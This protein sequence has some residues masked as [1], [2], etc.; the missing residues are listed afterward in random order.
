LASLLLDRGASVDHQ[1]SNGL[2][3]LMWFCQ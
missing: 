2:S 3:A 1:D